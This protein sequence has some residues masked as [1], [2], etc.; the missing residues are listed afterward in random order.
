MA[1][2]AARLS[3]SV[4]LRNSC[5]FDHCDAEELLMAWCFFFERTGRLETAPEAVRQWWERLKNYPLPFGYSCRSRTYLDQQLDDAILRLTK[6][7]ML[8]CKKRPAPK[9]PQK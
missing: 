6:H 1:T 4:S 7:E 9:R 8:V 3:E 2:L 5:D